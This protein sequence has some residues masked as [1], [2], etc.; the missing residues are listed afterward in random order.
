M[1][2]YQP[3]HHEPDLHLHYVLMTDCLP[4]C[5]CDTLHS[6]LLIS[7]VC[8]KNRRKRRRRRRWKGDVYCVHVCAY[9]CVWPSSIH[10]SSRVCCLFCTAM[11][12][13]KLYKP[14]CFWLNCIFFFFLFLPSHISLLIYLN[15]PIHYSKIGE[16]SST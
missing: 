16:M 4:I 1:K 14:T 12:H 8:R 7:T 6:W 15:T 11:W 5:L 9:V 3:N 10:V 13:N 2:S